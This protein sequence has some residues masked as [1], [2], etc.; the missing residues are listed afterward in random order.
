VVTSYKLPSTADYITNVKLGPDGNIWYALCGCGGEG[1]AGSLGKITPAGVATDY[2]VGFF[3]NDVVTGADKNIWFT[4]RSLAEV[5]S[6]L[7]AVA[8]RRRSARASRAS[9][10]TS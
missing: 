9:R 3:V 10:L 8:I 1:G 7:P 5:G 6:S 2:S 4:A